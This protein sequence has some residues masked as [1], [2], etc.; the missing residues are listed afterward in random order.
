M[1]PPAEPPTAG[2]PPSPPPEPPP[3]PAGPSPRP[4]KPPKPPGLREQAART[5]ASGRR[6]VDAHV[7]LGK[8]ELAVILEDAKRVAALVG[9]ALAFVL[10]IGLLVSVGMALFLGEWI[11]GS[12]G[13]GVLHGALLSAFLITAMALILVE[14]PRYC[15]ARGFGWGIALGLVTSLVLG[16]N[17]CRQAA[18]WAADQLRAGPFPALSV[19][20]G[21]AIVGVV[22]GAIVLAIIAVAIASYVPARR[23]GLLSPVSTLRGT[24]G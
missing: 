17:A 4:P 8:A 19:E 6:L 24:S 16:S 2:P 20:W 9:L 14:A 15:L 12:I 18:T 22:V 1:P 11:F 13:W 10:Y 7:A 5:Y 21:P 23:A 3:P